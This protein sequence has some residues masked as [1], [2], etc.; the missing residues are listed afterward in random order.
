MSQISLRK[1]LFYTYEN[2]AY[3]KNKIGDLSGACAD[4]KAAFSHPQ[5]LYPPIQKYEEFLK[6]RGKESAP[7]WVIE[8]CN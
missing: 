7:V 4:I 1:W 2:R 5:K 8:N 6:E 3:A